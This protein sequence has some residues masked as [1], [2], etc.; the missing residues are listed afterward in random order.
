MKTIHSDRLVCALVLAC[1]ASGCGGDPK[2][3]AEKHA[4]KA[5]AYA[6]KQQFEEAIIE[7]RR[8]L[9]LVPG[10]AAWHYKLG[11]AYEQSRDAVMAF[12]EF[13]RAAAL[14]ARNVDALIKSASGFLAAGD[15]EGA[16][17]RAELA[18]KADP[19]H[20]PAY[21]LLGNA[22][23]GL[24]NVDAAVRQIEQAVAL[25]Q[26]SAAAW[27]SL[28]TMKFLQGESDA[29]AAAFGK[30]IAV[31][32][33]SIDTRLAFANYHWARGAIRDAEQT[34]KDALALDAKNPMSHRMLAAF[35]V[36][37]GRTRE[38]EPHFRAL[39]TDAQGQLG[40][41]DFLTSLSRHDEAQQLLATVEAHKDKV[42]ARAARLRRAGV[43]H[44]I[45]KR[46]EAHQILDAMLHASP[47]DAELRVMKARLLLSEGAPGDAA[48]HAREAVSAQPGAPEAHYVSGVVA[49]ARGSLAEAVRAFETVVRINPRAVPAHMQLARIHLA[50]R[51]PAKAVTAAER[52]S[53]EQPRD[54]SA[55][56]LLVQGLRAQGNADRAA[57]ELERSLSHSPYAPALLLE[58][59]WLALSSRQMTAA[60]SAF[61]AALR[62]GG[63]DAGARSGL[64]ATDLAERKIDAARTRVR[65]WRI[66]APTDPALKVLA[67]RVEIAGGALDE[68]SRLL[69]EVT[70]TQPVMIEAY[71]LLANVYA[72]QGNTDRAIT[73]YELVAKH[74]PAASAGANTIAGMLHDTR[75]DQ[76]AARA[77]Y[78]R[79][80]AA[81][82]KAAV[83]ANNLAWIYAAEGNLPEALRLAKLATDLLPGRAEPEHTA[84]WI[85]Y[86]MG[87]TARAIAAFELA[88]LRTPDKPLYH[89]HAGLAYQKAGDTL[90]A[91]SA[92]EKAL[93]LDAKFAGADDARLQLER[94]E[95]QQREER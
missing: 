10:T 91:K 23:V 54:P 64:V 26:G 17:L 24:K 38:A 11:R 95:Q 87:L 56:A 82:P 29:A 42:L 50:S 51:E 88:R 39:A 28:G 30:A 47:R 74:A 37:S 78:E 3:A 65:A 5:D 63:A 40:L 70:S 57:H 34:L 6:A 76:A 92:F 12:Q 86:Q 81:D 66:E 46:V 61:E 9:Q 41:A 60:R 33:K 21:V 18:L 53:R 13:T 68:A 67:A 93:T 16:R 48:L 84:G 25:D 49:L 8:A 36:A 7:Y 85:Y 62:A 71:E 77:A 44:A 27:A 55:A 73:Q 20:A 75:H 2:A 83:A 14:D 72:L 35:Y 22:L 69:Q 58:K 90:R 15:F 32:P 4:A 45:G 79:A 52:A 43:L 1:L 89:Y 59:G 80:L 31:A 94:L 19:N